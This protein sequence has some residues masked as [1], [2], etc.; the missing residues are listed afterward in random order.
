MNKKKKKKAEH[1]A[2]QLI[3]NDKHRNSG[4]NFATAVFLFNIFV[5]NAESRIKCNLSKFA[6]DTKVCGEVDMWKGRDSIQRDLAGLRE[7]HEI[8]QSQ[9]PGPASGLG[10]SEMQIQAGQKKD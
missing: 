3:R 8:Q 2:G 4:Y 9:V 7:P 10:Q 1:I 6:N 5:N